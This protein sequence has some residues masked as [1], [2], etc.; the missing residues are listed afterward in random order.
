[1]E[2]LIQVFSTSDLILLQSY[3]AA[4]SPAVELV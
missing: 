4:D 1:M 3:H 2:N